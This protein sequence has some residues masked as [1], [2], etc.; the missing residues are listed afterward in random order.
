MK[1][2]ALTITNGRLVLTGQPPVAGNLRA[3]GDRIV[4]LGDVAPEAGD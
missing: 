3:V 2:T 4:A 1:N